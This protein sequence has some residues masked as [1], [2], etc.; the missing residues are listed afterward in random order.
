[1]A[2]FEKDSIAFVHPATLGIYAY[3]LVKSARRLSD[4]EILVTLQKGGAGTAAP[5]PVK[6]AVP[7]GVRVGDVVENISW[8][9]RLTFRHNVVTG[10]NTRGLLVT[11]RRKVVIEENEFDRVGMQAI[12]IADDALSWYE[13]GSVRDVLIRGN[14]FREGGHNAL[15]GN[16]AIAIAPENHELIPSPVHRN[17]RIEGNRF[18]CYN[19]PVLAARSVEGLSFMNNTV[20]YNRPFRGMPAKGLLRGV[21][22]GVIPGHAAASFHLV[23]CRDVVIGN[24]R[25]DRELPG[26]NIKMEA[27]D[28]GDLRVIGK[29]GLRLD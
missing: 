8:T 2:F 3:A 17:I 22:E 14:V 9:P 7:S 10:T 19:A 12:L 13:S 28:K 18:Y 25:I 1:M 20:M 6:T 5:S 26:R 27:M 11:T 4:R 23:S 29:G 16:Y 21:A 15:P 24:N